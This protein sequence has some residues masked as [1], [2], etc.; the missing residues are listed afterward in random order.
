MDAAAS[1]TIR[2]ARADEVERLPAIELAAAQLFRGMD[3]GTFSLD[4]VQSVATLAAAQR[5]RQLWVAVQGDTPVG[6]AVA[7]HVGGEPHLRE[8]D[9]QPA[10]GQRGLGARLVAAV[11][12]WARAQGA[13]SLTLSTFRDVAWNAPFYAKL[14]FRALDPSELDEPHRALLEREAAMGLPR[15]RRVVMRLTLG[16]GS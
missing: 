11:I 3:I 1:Y 10:H 4:D 9:V 5:D 16:A 7:S 6:F 12:E 15:E 2:I 8:L 14:G 13:P